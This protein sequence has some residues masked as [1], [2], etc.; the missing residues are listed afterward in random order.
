MA[1]MAVMP[2]NSCVEAWE[3]EK[4]LQAANPVFKIFAGLVPMLRWR[5]L[6]AETRMALLRAAVAVQLEG[7]RALENRTD[8]INNEPFVQ[9]PC[10]DGGFELRT[11]EGLKDDLRLKLKLDEKAKEPLTLTVGESPRAKNK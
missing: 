8:P 11:K 5:Q 9:V 2:L 6:Q 10:K 4:Q 1:Q 7:A 3:T